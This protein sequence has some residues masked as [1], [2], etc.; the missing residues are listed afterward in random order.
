MIYEFGFLGKDL[1]VGG[2][3]TG[4]GGVSARGLAKWNGT[5]WSDVGGF[6]GVALAMP[7]VAGW[8]TV[9]TIRAT[10]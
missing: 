9:H 4:A 6:S 2:V 3:F 10:P 7:Y 8:S 1:Y 5:S